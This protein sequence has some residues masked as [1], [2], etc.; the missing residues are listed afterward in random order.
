[1]QQGNSSPWTF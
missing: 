1:C